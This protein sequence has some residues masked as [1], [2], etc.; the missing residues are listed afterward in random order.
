MPVPA[1]SVPTPGV[2]AAAIPGGD[3]GSETVIEAIG[4]RK[5]YGDHVAVRD[6]SFQVHAGEVFGLLGPNG[7]GKTTTVLMLLGLTEPTAGS[8]RVVGVDPMRDPLAVKRRVGYVPDSV[9]FYDRL[10]GRANLAYT[11][12]LNGIPGS[13]A[14]PRIGALLEQAGLADVADH[15]VETYSRG[16][17]QRLGIADALVKDPAVLILDE[18]TV[19]LDPEGVAELLELIA[20][21]ADERG[22]AILLSSH[23]LDQVQAVCHR[24]GIFFGGRLVAAGTIADLA[25]RGGDPGDVV[26]LGLPAGGSWRADDGARAAASSLVAGLPSVTTVADDPTF[27]GRLLVRVPHGGAASLAGDLAAAGLAPIHFRIREERLDAIYRRLVHAAADEAGRGSGEAGGADASAGGDAS[28]GADAS[29]SADLDVRAGERPA[30]R[31]S[32]SAPASPGAAEPAR[33]PAIWR[34]P[35]RHTTAPAGG[36]TAPDTRPGAATNRPAA[37]ADGD[38]S[39]DA[40]PSGRPDAEPSGRPEVEP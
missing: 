23:L 24:V 13:V 38:R 36:A 32:R 39:P 27:P 15:R 4:L 29:P 28:A 30:Q 26:E 12:R 31:R 35:S 20:R 10:S 16:M 21:I 18:P 33:P 22:I 2:P 40:E 11:A 6:L 8:A 14:G 9:G 37:E 17:R 1:P 3:A 19:S 34:R 25:A 7:A 5:T